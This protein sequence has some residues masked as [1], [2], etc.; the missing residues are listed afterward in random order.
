MLAV[1]L[2]AAVC[3]MS[4]TPVPDNAMLAGELVA[5]LATLTLPVRLPEEAGAKVTLRVTAWLGVKVVPEV[6]PLALKLAPEA[7]T[8]ERV[9]FEFPVLV[10]LALSKLLLPK[11]TLPKL[12]LVGFAVSR[13]VAVTPVPLRAIVRG[14]LGA[15]LTSETVPVTLPA[16]LGVKTTLNVALLP[17]AMVRGTVMP[18]RLK[19]LPDTVAWEIARLALPALDS[20]MVCELLV[21]VATLPK[22]ALVGVG[23]SC[24]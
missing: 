5:L 15:L 16:A 9:T 12:R 2:K 13:K 19:P 1:Q 3:A 18:V 22:L 23:A 20:L 24:G 7:V 21:P 4:C 10:K 6:T 8:L 14:E 17:A 11:F